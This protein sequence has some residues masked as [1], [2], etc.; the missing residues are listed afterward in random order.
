MLFRTLC[1]PPFELS[2]LCQNPTQLPSAF[3]VYPIIGIGRNQLQ[4]LNFA[5]VK[6]SFL[7]LLIYSHL[8]HLLNIYLDFLRLYIEGNRLLIKKYK[9]DMMGR[10]KRLYIEETQKNTYSLKNAFKGVLRRFKIL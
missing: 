9:S 2:E 6:Y 8:A 1:A 7:A 5:L 10:K 3:R 4:A